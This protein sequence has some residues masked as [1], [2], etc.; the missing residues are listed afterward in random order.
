[1]KTLEEKRGKQNDPD[2][3]KQAKG[4]SK[5]RG[6][7]RVMLKKQGQGETEREREREG[8]RERER[9]TVRALL[10]VL[11]SYTP[12]RIHNRMVKSSSQVYT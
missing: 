9:E 10:L 4:R 8:E 12:F 5:K 2:G 7:K 3:P 1:M 6:I 11:S